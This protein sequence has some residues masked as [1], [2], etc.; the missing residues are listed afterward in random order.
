MSKFFEIQP[1]K[2]IHSDQIVSVE[3]KVASYN[4]QGDPFKYEIVTTLIDGRTIQSGMDHR[5]VLEPIF[6]NMIA[7]LNE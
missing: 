1:D 7:Q 5:V 6:N 3:M 4:P 2:Y